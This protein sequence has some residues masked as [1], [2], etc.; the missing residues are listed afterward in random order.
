MHMTYRHRLSQRKR[1]QLSQFFAGDGVVVR[2]ARGRYGTLP[3][4]VI[5]LFDR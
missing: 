2:D 5:G 3:R 4:I 1:C